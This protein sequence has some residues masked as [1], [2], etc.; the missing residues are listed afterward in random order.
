MSAPRMMPANAPTERLFELDE[1]SGGI[2][3]EVED[4]LGLDDA[5]VFE[6]E[7]FVAAKISW[8]LGNS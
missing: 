2:F 1:A 4:A 3:V 5:N 8:F 7:I 6:N